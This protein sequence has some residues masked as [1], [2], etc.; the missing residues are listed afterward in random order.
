MPLIET[1]AVSILRGWL[2]KSL[3]SQRSKSSRPS[4]SLGSGR[5]GKPAAL[6]ISPFAQSAHPVTISFHIRLI[7]PSE[8][9]SVSSNWRPR[10][11]SFHRFDAQ[12]SNAGLDRT[13][14]SHPLRVVPSSTP[15]GTRHWFLNEQY[16]RYQCLEREPYLK[17]ADS[18]NESLSISH[19]SSFV[20]FSLWN[21][22][23]FCC[24][25]FIS[26]SIVYNVTVKKHE[27]RER[28]R[29]KA[30]I[31][32]SRPLIAGWFSSYS[33]PK[34]TRRSRWPASSF[35]CKSPTQSY[36]SV[37]F[38][39]LIRFI[40]KTCCWLQGGPRITFLADPTGAAR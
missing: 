12:E 24:C 11:V 26:D 1:D 14:V 38:V 39:S 25:P 31:S 34:S 22:K 2:R 28:E 17:R 5:S 35:L 23:S 33:S 15:H 10:F 21:A 20:S 27:M 29:N 37:L 30:S 40:R 16:Y 18:I 6:R 9:R 36:Y 32:R 13:D 4:Q 7:W 3:R 8:P 19:I